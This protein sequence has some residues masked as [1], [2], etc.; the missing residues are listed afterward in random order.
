MTFELKLNDDELHA[1][2]RVIIE[3]KFA[4]DP[5]DTDIAGSPLVADIANRVFSVALFGQR[6]HKLHLVDYHRISAIARK[7]VTECAAAGLWR[8]MTEDQQFEYICAV[9]APY[10]IDTEALDEIRRLAE[11]V[12][13]VERREIHDEVSRGLDLWMQ[14]VQYQPMTRDLNVYVGDTPMGA[15]VRKIAFR[16]VADFRSEEKGCRTAN[17]PDFDGIDVHDYGVTVRYR[18]CAHD[19]VISFAADGEYEVVEL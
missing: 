7:R 4:E 18:F 12:K 11:S 1:L 19:C 17:G 14:E 10:E 16:S 8:T 6:A 5:S 3:S 2:R 9:C 13:V 15:P